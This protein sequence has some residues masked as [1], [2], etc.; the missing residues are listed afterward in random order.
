VALI[1][2]LKGKPPGKGGYRRE[3]EE[4]EEEEVKK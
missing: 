3:R 2:L 4:E 1:N